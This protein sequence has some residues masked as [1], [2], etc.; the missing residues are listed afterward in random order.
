MTSRARRPLRSGFTT[1]A[2]AAAAAAAALELSLTGRAPQ[3]V[4]IPFL[5]EG[6]VEIPVHSA[7]RLPDAQAE[8]TVLKDAGDDPDVTHGAEIGARVRLAEPWE[9]APEACPVAIAGG[10][11]VGRVTQPGLEVPPGEAAINPGP[12]EMIIRAVRSVLVRTGRSGRVRVEVFVPRGAELARRTLNARLGILGGISILGTTGVV[13]PMSH[14]AYSAT[15]RSALSVARATGL[16][17]V[18]LTTGRRS[19]RH[20]QG[21]YPELPERAFVQMGDFF[22]FALETAAGL[23]FAG[24]ALVVF[25]GKAVKMAQG[26]AHTHAGRAD[27]ALSQLAAWCREAGISPAL[28]A[29][30]AAANTARQAFERLHPAA[31][32]ALAAVGA[33][34]LTAARNLSN[35]PLAIEALILDYDGGVAWQGRADG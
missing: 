23:G 6:G 10:E 3:A 8:A 2:A 9:G 15:I 35:A 30:V 21:L 5:S 24:V 16:P 33:R 28:A 32:A 34:I 26:L 22:G 11:G 4:W 20:A 27:L 13:R 18:V 7:R 1:G 25:F 14:E 12:R 29:E 19:E 17:R 31:P